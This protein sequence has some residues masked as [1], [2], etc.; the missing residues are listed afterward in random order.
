M[1]CKN[2]EVAR[3]AHSRCN[4]EN[5]N[6]VG[7]CENFEKKAFVSSKFLPQH[8]NVVPKYPFHMSYNNKVVAETF[9]KHY[10]FLVKK[11]VGR[12]VLQVW[13]GKYVTPRYPLHT[14]CRNMGWGAT[15]HNFDIAARI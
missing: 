5:R 13:V 3:A 14:S 15:G 8:N 11:P 9:R 4:Y 6:I 7:K 2:R 12:G 10:N 1:S